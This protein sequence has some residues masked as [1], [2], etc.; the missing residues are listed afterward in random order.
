LIASSTDNETTLFSG[1]SEQGLIGFITTTGFR[2]VGKI[3]A[4]CGLAATNEDDPDVRL[5]LVVA[6][7]P[8]AS[9]V[10]EAVFFERAFSGVLR[11]G[12]TGAL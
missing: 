10:Y 9:E 4:T 11:I 1:T 7:A 12:G 6:V 3:A 8:A 5:L 2:I